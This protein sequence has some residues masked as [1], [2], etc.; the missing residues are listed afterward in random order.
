M[1]ADCKRETF[2]RG[3]D[4][5]N[6]QQFFDCHEIL[7]EIWLEEPPKEKLFYQGIIQVAAAFHH[8]HNRNL[9]GARSLMEAGAAKLCRYP[10]HHYGIDVA[11]FLTALAPWLEALR[12]RQAPVQLALPTIR[13]A[14]DA[15]D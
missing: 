9:R 1:D 13:P 12:R 7:E 8:V 6:R 11:A 15:R 14:G 10:A 2:W 5:F 3:I 4:S